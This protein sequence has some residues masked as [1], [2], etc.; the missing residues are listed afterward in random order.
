MKLINIVTIIFFIFTCSMASTS[1]AQLPT[2]RSVGDGFIE[3]LNSGRQ[4]SESSSRNQYLEHRMVIEQQEYEAQI[5]QMKQ[6]YELKQLQI[7]LM[8][9]QVKNSHALNKK[10]KLR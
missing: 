4:L 3:G 10:I 1:Y 7:Q 2:S 9:E 8:K 6:D 5:A